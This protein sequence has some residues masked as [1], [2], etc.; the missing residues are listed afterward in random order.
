[1]PQQ[2][3]TLLSSADDVQH[4]I[5]LGL[6]DD[7]AGIVKDDVVAALGS[8]LDETLLEK[9]LLFGGGV[10]VLGGGGGMWGV[11]IFGED[12][13]AVGGGEDEDCVD[14]YRGRLVR[15]G[16]HWER[17][18]VIYRYEGEIRGHYADVGG[19]KGGRGE[20]VVVGGG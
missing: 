10:G 18:Y 5:T 4:D 16:G 17:L 19:G 14:L 2:H 9:L 20:V 11:E 1:M 7:D 12:A 15:L 13:G 6:E 3:L 8:L